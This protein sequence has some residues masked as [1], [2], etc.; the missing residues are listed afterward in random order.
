LD[1]LDRSL[2]W[3]DDGVDDGTRRKRDRSDGEVVRG[4][5]LHR[6]AL[7][8]NGQIIEENLFY[9]VVGMMKQIGLG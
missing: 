9:D 7:D 3:H 5:L 6:G 2:H 1:V 8:A 4:R